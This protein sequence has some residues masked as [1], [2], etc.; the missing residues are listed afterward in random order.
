MKR[1][2]IILLMCLVAV[3]AV[4]AKSKFPDYDITG[5]GSGNEGRVL[6]KVYVYGKS[7][8]D[9][10]L[11]MCAAHGIVFRGCTGNM[12]GANQPAMASPT[13]MTDMATFCEEFFSTSGQ[14][15]AY[16]SIV[17]GSYDRV[18]T[19]K[20]YKC[21]AIVEV[22]KTALR[23]ALEQAGVVRKLGAGF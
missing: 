1:L 16:A 9:A 21:G 10:E 2:S 15:Q 12:S 7:A 6:V 19:S 8:S 4:M 5:A 11:K 20:G 18:K 13:V 23:Q 3:S 22:N 17:A 14:V